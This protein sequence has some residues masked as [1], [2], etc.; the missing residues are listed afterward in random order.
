MTRRSLA[1][2][3]IGAPVASAIWL[4][5]PLI[6]SVIVFPVENLTPNKDH[7]YLCKGTSAELMSRLLRV[8]GLR[9]I[10]FYEPQSRISRFPPEARFAISG[11]LQ[12]HASD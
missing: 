9:V 7:D 4:A 8:D 1:F 6:A 12:D 10:P 3:S 2:A 5:R 11:Y